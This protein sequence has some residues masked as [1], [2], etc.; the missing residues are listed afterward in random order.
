[1]WLL[2]ESNCK[3]G[4]AKALAETY[5]DWSADDIEKGKHKQVGIR[6]FFALYESLRTRAMQ[7]SPCS[8]E[9]PGKEL[10]PE[11]TTQRHHDDPASSQLGED[12]FATY[13]QPIVNLVRNLVRGFVD[14]C[15]KARNNDFWQPGQDHWVNL[16]LDLE[17]KREEEKSQ[18]QAQA[19]SGPRQSYIEVSHFSFTTYWEGAQASS[20]EGQASSQ[21]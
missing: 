17:R 3:K 8:A 11:F 14:R 9:N 19:S 15:V 20:Q 4:N 5:I 2:K 12:P 10:W 13:V 21:V 6:R 18:A 16:R 1:V 7:G